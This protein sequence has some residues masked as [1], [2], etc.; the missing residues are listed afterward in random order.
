VTP[1]ITAEFPGA[2]GYLNT[3]SIGLPP[4]GAVHAMHTAIDDWQMGRARAGQYDPVVAQARD[5]FASLVG[6][7]VESVAVGAQVSALVAVAASGLRPGSHVLCPEGEFTSV[8]F[9]FLARPDL[10]L[11]MRE[12]PL[13][14]LADEV[15][16]NTALV[17]F[18]VVQSSS[19]AVAAIDD[20][21]AAAAE[22]DALTM[23]DATQAA[24]WFPLHALDFDIL[25]AGA[26]KWLLSP[27]GTAFMTVRPELLDQL[28]PLYAG[29]YSGE[30]PWESI[31]GLPLRVAGSARRFDLSP[32]WIAWVGTAPAVEMLLETGVAEIH[33]HNVGLANEL[34]ARLDRPPAGS[35]IV[36]LD[37]GRG[38]DSKR[39]ARFATAYRAG[40]L[41]VAFHL[42]NTSE[43]VDRLVAAITQ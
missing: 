26:Y 28:A 4:Q 24:G 34:C 27:R 36:S 14:H 42:Y 39:L 5:R 3:A 11:E 16:P 1:D 25:V 7:P 33:D 31:Y 19:G 41:R 22:H 2:P 9:P 23:A 13:Q 8:T 10:N 20:I 17:A 35:A 32:G 43:D 12:V 6:A 18:S 21:R 30:D 37:L 29:W 38:F 40:R 15:R